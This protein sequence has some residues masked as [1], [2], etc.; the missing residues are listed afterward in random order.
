M[1]P[2]TVIRLSFVHFTVIMN[3][4]SS[5]PTGFYLSLELTKDVTEAKATQCVTNTVLKDELQLDVWL[6]MK[7]EN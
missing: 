1:W 7:L 2:L 5:Y 6:I 4:T 3:L